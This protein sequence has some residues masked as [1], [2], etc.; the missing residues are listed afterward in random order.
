[1]AVRPICVAAE[2]VFKDFA[3]QRPNPSRPRCR[4]GHSSNYDQIEESWSKNSREQLLPFL[5]AGGSLD[6]GRDRPRRRC[7]CGRFLSMAG[8]E[9]D[10]AAIVAPSMVVWALVES[11]RHRRPPKRG[12]KVVHHRPGRFSTFPV[13]RGTE[14][15]SSVQPSTSPPDDLEG[16]VGPCPEPGRHDQQE[17]RS[18]PLGQLAS[19]AAVDSIDLISSAGSCHF[20][21]SKIIL[22]DDLLGFPPSKPFQARIPCPQI[23]LGDGK[24][25]EGRGL[26][27]SLPPAPVRVVKT[28][29]PSPVRGRTRKGM[30][31]RHGR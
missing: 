13:G 26:S 27:R 9:V 11:F 7:Q 21:S 24:G 10:G 31:E 6:I 5:R 15:V 17:M 14:C 30:S 22:K 2:K 25:V 23:R 29:S 28:R 1:V 19:I 12:A 3:A 4:D 8:G 20:P 18:R 16:G